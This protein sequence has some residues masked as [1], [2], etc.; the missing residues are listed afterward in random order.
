[1]NIKHEAVDSFEKL[2]SQELIDFI[3]NTVSHYHWRDGK[4]YHDGSVGTISMSPKQLRD[5]LAFL[6]RVVD[7]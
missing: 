2:E 7:E 4:K 3:K 1:M 6:M 5:L